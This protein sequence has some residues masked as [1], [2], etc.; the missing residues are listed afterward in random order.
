VDQAFIKRIEY[1]NAKLAADQLRA[2]DSYTK[3]RR[4][5]SIFIL[6]FKLMDDDKFFHRYRFYD[7][8]SGKELADLTEVVIIEPSKIR[9]I[10]DDSVKSS[11][12]K[13]F[14]AE[15]E[16][17]LKMLE[18]N[19]E[20]AEAVATIRRFSKDKEAWLEYE[21]EEK[22]R[23]GYIAQMESARNEGEAAGIARGRTEE[24]VGIA[25]GMLQKGLDI[26]IISEIAKLSIP[27]IEALKQR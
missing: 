11:W 3:L 8:E 22:A 14:N 7:R 6:N 5:V 17:D 21:A 18:A 19:P 1:C 23:K 2:G 20:L 13:L 26:S 12:A 15:T 25:L 27:E 4:S 10:T 16:E 9:E 24:R